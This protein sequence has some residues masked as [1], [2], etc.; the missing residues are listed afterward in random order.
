MF[1]WLLLADISLS[2]MPFG[3]ISN[4]DN[5]KIAF[6]FLKTSTGMAEFFVFMLHQV[7]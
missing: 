4:E 5:P 3:I 1:C 7:T 2:R 6:V